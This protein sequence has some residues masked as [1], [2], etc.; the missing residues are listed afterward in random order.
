MGFA[1]MRYN[2]QQ[3]VG[4]GESFTCVDFGSHTLTGNESIYVTY[5]PSQDI[6]GIDIS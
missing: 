5:N 2:A 1:S 4:N 6:T 3:D